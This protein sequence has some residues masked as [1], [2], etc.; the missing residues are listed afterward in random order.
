M[1]AF[2]IKL[3]I[4]VIKLFF[5]ILLFRIFLLFSVISIDTVNFRVIIKQNFKEQMQRT[6]QGLSDKYAFRELPGG[7]RQ[8]HSLIGYPLRAVRANIKQ[9]YDSD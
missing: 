2:N 1:P 9:P 3:F 4:Q 8:Q 6:G 7:V 5:I